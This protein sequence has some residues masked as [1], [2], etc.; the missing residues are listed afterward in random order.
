MQIICPSGLQGITFSVWPKRC[1]QI[2]RNFRYCV[3]RIRFRN[4]WKKENC[5]RNFEKL[6]TYLWCFVTLLFLFIYISVFVYQICPLRRSEYLIL[7]FQ[8]CRMDTLPSKSSE[9]RISTKIKEV[10]WN[11]ASQIVVFIYI[12]LIEIIGGWSSL[13][14][15]GRSQKIKMEI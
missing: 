11:Y 12:M 7:Q 4:L 15:K 3:V 9:I 6:L 13:I 1:L 10:V 8:L 2:I 5:H 14:S